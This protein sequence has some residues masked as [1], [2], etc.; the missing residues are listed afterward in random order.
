MPLT[1]LHPPLVP[2]QTLSLQ[3]H[4]PR[5]QLRGTLGRAL[6]PMRPPPTRAIATS[7]SQLPLALPNPLSSQQRQTRGQIHLLPPRQFPV[8]PI[9]AIELSIIHLPLL[10]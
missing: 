2:G 10:V 3:L 8:H 4:P 6:L 1:S 5:S 9:G 7:M